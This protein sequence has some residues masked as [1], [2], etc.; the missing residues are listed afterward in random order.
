MIIAKLVSARDS[1]QTPCQN[2]SSHAWCRASSE[3]AA[4]LPEVLQ[5][6]FEQDVHAHVPSNGP[7]PLAV[8]AC[9]SLQ[10]RKLSL[11]SWFTPKH[12]E[13]AQRILRGLALVAAK[14]A[15]DR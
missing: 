13:D 5:R 9:G 12:F 10:H 15:A 4:I 14:T 2:S 11:M 1:G 3:V 7:R 6:C 8:A